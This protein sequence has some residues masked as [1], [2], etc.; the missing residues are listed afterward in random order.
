MNK[1]KFLLV[2]IVLLAQSCDTTEPPIKTEPPKAITLKMLEVS[3]TE[4]F[5]KITA[6]DTILPVSITINKDEKALYNIT[7]TKPVTVIIDTTLQPNATYIYQT[8]AEINNNPEKSDTLQVKTLNITSD[9]YT[10]QTFEFGGV[11]GSSQ[12]S[13]VAIINENN[14]WAVGAI[15]AD[16]TGQAYNAVHWDGTEWELKRIMFNTICGQNSN[17]PYPINSLLILPNDEI[18]FAAGDQIAI[19]KNNILSSVFCLPWSF[20]IKKIWGSSGSDVYVVGDNG[21]IAHYLNGSWSKIESGTDYSIKDIY[22]SISSLTGEREILCSGL[23]ETKDSEVIRINENSTTEK[24]D[25]I[26]LRYALDIWFKSGI[27]YYTVGDGL[28]EKRY[29]HTNSW[30]NLNKNL[31]ITTYFMNGIDGNGLNDIIVCGAFG[32]ILHY[33]GISWK[34]LKNEETTIE[35]G[36]YFDVKTKENIV[37][38]VGFDGSRAVT[39]VGKRN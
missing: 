38:A 21:N 10:W 36:F 27:R 29:D 25:K 17:T 4:A 33:N 32:E 26:G 39:L 5:I 16:T 11:G 23:G 14:I 19:L 34:S 31:A 20:S 28:F 6:N 24:T 2:F 12:L 22:S 1:I 30:K 37:V 15:Y 13:D 35:S 18:W 7:L 8:E 9:N 3:C